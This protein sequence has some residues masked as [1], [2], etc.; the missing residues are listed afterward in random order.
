MP[1][2]GMTIDSLNTVSSLTAQD[3]VPV[4]DNESSGEPTRKITAQNMT[5]SVKT[6][7]SLVNTT[8][9]NNAIQQSTAIEPFSVVISPAITDASNISQNCY[10]SVSSNTVFITI[11]IV[12]NRGLIPTA[13][14]TV[15]TVPSKYRPSDARPVGY[16]IVCDDKLWEP[17]A[18][19]AYIDKSGAFKLN[20][21][22]YG[23]KTT[24]MIM[25][26]GFYNL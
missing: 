6:L 9:M 22:V 1:T 24:Y 18:E 2:N 13:N 4:W 12:S 25:F 10:Y 21:F 3:K 7:G 14:N 20:N 8:E 19:S 16:A 26:S 23:T 5:N 11:R 15:F 17:K